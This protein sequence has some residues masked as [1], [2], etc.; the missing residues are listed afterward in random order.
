MQIATPR[1]IQTAVI[2][3]VLAVAICSGKAVAQEPPQ[4]TPEP[5]KVFAPPPVISEEERQRILKTLLLFGSG[6]PDSGPAPLKVKFT[7]EV[8]DDDAVKPKFE[9]NF[10]DGSKPSREQNP[11]HTYKKVGKYLATVR[12]TD[13]K[14]RSGKDEVMIWAEEE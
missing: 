13:A 8:Y 10:G 1:L 5:P 11:T 7:V 12:A 3:M 4:P 6:E 2:S 14:G 9:W